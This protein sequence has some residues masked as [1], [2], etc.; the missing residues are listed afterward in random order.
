MDLYSPATLE[1]M[2]CH[3][4][5]ALAQDLNLQNICV[6]S[7]CLEVIEN[8]HNRYFGCYGAAIREIKET[9][10]SF[11]SLFFRH[12]SRSSN[13][14]AHRL[15]HSS[16]SLECGRRLWLLRPPKGLCIPLNVSNN[17]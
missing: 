4:A 14:E 16:V 8:R 12:E 17:Q 13:G 2:A 7:D 6:E 10:I 3:E 9:S 1:E 11:T 15:A 5:L